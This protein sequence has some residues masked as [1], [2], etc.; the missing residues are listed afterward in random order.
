MESDK[1]VGAS[2]FISSGQKRSLIALLLVV[3][4]QSLGVGAML[5]ALPGTVGLVINALSRLWMLTFPFFWTGHVERRRPHLTGPTRLGMLAGGISGVVIALVMLGVYF[6]AADSIDVE[7]IRDR[8]KTTG[9][10]AP[11]RFGVMLGFIVLFNSLLEEY[12][13]RWFVVRQVEG[14]LPSSMGERMRTTLA[15]VIAAGL[16]TVHHVVAL[17]AWVDIPLVMLGST[18]VFLGAIIWSFLFAYDGS[19]WPS[20]LSHVMA[21]LAI[22]AIGY[23]VLFR[24]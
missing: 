14:A 15:V 6:L 5:L 24:R 3:P 18:G 22:L 11:I 4:V 9:F 8:A 19:L 23:D 21:D 2:V 16:F 1:T 13:W 12:F 17:V 7:Q 20:Y 10:D